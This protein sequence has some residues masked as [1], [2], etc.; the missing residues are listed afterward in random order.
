MISAGTRVVFRLSGTGSHGAT[1][2]L[3]AEKYTPPPGRA[4]G[5]EG[6][7]AEPEPAAAEAEGGLAGGE[8]GKAYPADLEVE[9]A[10]ALAP[11]ITAALAL[12]KLQELTG[13]EAPTV[14][15]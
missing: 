1:I 8:E 13:R 2:R 11:L 10:E 14:I 3:Y 12:S 5:A 9:T 7:D 15:T 6:E 4:G